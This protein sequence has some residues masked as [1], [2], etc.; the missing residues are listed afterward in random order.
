MQCITPFRLIQGALRAMSSS[1]DDIQVVDPP[2]LSSKSRSASRTPS[3]AGPSRS[4]AQTMV[5]QD[6]DSDDPVFVGETVGAKLAAKFT[7]NDGTDRAR[8]PSALSSAAESRSRST[9]VA[10]G[11]KRKSLEKAGPERAQPI[12][13]SVDEDAE[14]KTDLTGAPKARQSTNERNKARRQRD[15]SERAASASVA[16]SDDGREDKRHVQVK[17]QREPRRKPRLG[18]NDVLLPMLNTEPLPVPDWLGQ[19]VVLRQLSICPLC[20]R[21]LKQAESGPARWVSRCKKWTLTTAA[22]FV[23]LS[24]AIS[25]SQHPARPPKDPQ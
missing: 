1:S 11:R 2:A 15:K 18:V 16:G 19:P 17:V 25:A 23:L 4:T 10:A 12:D 21:Q 5:E 7:F 6:S 24:T 3:R 13:L 20:K 14:V 8:M 22:H 9:S